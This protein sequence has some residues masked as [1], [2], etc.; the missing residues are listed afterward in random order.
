MPSEASVVEDVLTLL[1]RLTEAAGCPA[2][3]AAYLQ[4]L[5]AQPVNL[6]VLQQTKCGV[7]VA[8]LRTSGDVQIVALAGGL[9]KKW[10]RVAEE[11]GV[12]AATR[13]PA[14]AVSQATP[15]QVEADA[16]KEAPASSSGVVAH[17][18]SPPLEVPVA[19]V[20][21]TANAAPARSAPASGSAAA[22]AAAFPRPPAY[23]LPALSSAR[24]R[25]RQ[26][27]VDMLIKAVQERVG[28]RTEGAGGGG[29]GAPSP[30]AESPT[31]SSPPPT[32]R[33][34]LQTAEE[35][36]AQAGGAATALEAALFAAYGG[37]SSDR[38]APAYTEHFRVLA[39]ALPRNPPLVLSI[40]ASLLPL[41]DVVRMTSDEL[42]SDES[43]AKAERVRKE[44]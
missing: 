44:A 10:K 5:D 43:R 28:L 1:K 24:S 15:T 42:A 27:F 34:L 18:S 7:A 31:R 11:A 25:P 30:S 13:K 26:I 35:V 4:A 22:A 20:A 21:A 23:A 41:D 12:A 6:A 9:V 19:P 39:M 17:G 40:Y 2:D 8:K 36:R 3:A 33:Q 38:L 32:P 29:G 14:V 16:K 37:P